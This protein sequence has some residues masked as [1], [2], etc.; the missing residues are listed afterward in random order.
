MFKVDYKCN[1]VSVSYWCDIMLG[2]YQSLSIQG[3]RKVRKIR[4]NHYVLILSIKVICSTHHKK[5]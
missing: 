5:S 4:K 1:I 3:C 2:N